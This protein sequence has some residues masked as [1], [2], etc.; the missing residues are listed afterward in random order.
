MP[1]GFVAAAT[2]SSGTELQC[3][4]FARILAAVVVQA[5]L[6]HERGVATKADIDTALRYGTNY[7]RGPFEWLERIG[8][9]VCRRLLE[10]LHE[11]ASD[12]RFAVPALS[13][14]E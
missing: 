1:R 6:A 4:V 5:A 2:E 11:T 13:L 12:N 3:Y 14:S 8:S 10:T 9:D 7:P